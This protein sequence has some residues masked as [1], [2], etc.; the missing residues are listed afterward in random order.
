MTGPREIREGDFEGKT[1]SKFR[2]GD[3]EEPW[4]FWFSDGSA[5]AILWTY[6]G[7]LVE[8]IRGKTNG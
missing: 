4:Q 3:Q 7:L 1:I 8:D 5:I 6:D 2:S